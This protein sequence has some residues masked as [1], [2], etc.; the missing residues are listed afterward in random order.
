MPQFAEGASLWS[1]VGD[2]IAMDA[3]SEAPLIDEHDVIHAQ[4]R[5]P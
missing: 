2:K 3:Q 4:N 1:T 5:E